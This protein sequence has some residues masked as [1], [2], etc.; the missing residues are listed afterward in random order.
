MGTGRR[1][2]L[3]SLFIA[4]RTACAIVWAESLGTWFSLEPAGL[5]VLPQV[6]S[7]TAAVPL[8]QRVRQ[9][10]LARIK[11]EQI[12]DQ[13][14]SRDERLTDRRSFRRRRRRRRRRRLRRLRLRRLRNNDRSPANYPDRSHP[15]S[16]RH[17]FQVICLPLLPFLSFLFRLPFLCKQDFVQAS[18]HGLEQQQQQQQGQAE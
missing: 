1:G 13:R 4:Q 3:S 10:I 12:S 6:R 11:P 17:V 7:M 16:T 2:L 14:V 8:R 9:N 15:A 5:S 18:R